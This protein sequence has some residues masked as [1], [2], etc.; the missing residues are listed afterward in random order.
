MHVCASVDALERHRDHSSVAPDWVSLDITSEGGCDE[1]A[2]QK[3]RERA[4]ELHIDCFAE[5][6]SGRFMFGRLSNE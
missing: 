1:E 5:A 4:D 6:Y 2:C 3:R